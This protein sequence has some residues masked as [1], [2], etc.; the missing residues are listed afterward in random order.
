[1]VPSSSDSIHHASSSPGQGQSRAALQRLPGALPVLGPQG[2]RQV[3][4]LHR[5]GRGKGWVERP[6]SS[7]VAEERAGPAPLPVWDPAFTQ[8]TV[9]LADLFHT[10]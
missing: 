9:P 10:H 6:L 7:Q 5:D 4:W 3:S 1:M 8:Q 2:R